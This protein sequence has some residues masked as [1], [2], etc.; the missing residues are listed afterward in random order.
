MMARM[1]FQLQYSPHPGSRA[2]LTSG[3][4]TAATWSSAQ[5]FTSF[6]IAVM[7]R[8]NY[9]LPVNLL[10]KG[11]YELARDEANSSFFP[12]YNILMNE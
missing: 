6:D 4:R 8:Q 9:D 7:L 2:F 12:S 11:G 10:G 5:S 1:S 3:S